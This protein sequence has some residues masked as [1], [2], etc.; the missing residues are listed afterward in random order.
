MKRPMRVYRVDDLPVVC[1]ECGGRVRWVASRFA[2]VHTTRGAGHAP[3][4]AGTVAR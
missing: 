1:L 2:W 4:I 3:R